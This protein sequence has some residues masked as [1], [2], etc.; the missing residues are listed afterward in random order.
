MLWYNVAM[1]AC[2]LLKL[3]VPDFNEQ[4]DFKRNDNFIK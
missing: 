3:K 4:F 1:T 2:N